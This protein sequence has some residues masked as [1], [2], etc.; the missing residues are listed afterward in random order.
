LCL[1]EP[2]D[3]IKMARVAGRMIK[4]SSWS[5]HVVLSVHGWHL[6]ANCSELSSS[7]ALYYY[8]HL[9]VHLLLLEKLLI[10]FLAFT[11]TE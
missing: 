10:F 1:A 2:S 4:K 5:H 7:G 3:T 11:D 8:C 9:G 6:R